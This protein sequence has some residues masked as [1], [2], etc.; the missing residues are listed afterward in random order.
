MCVC[1]CV[2]VCVRERERERLGGGGGRHEAVSQ[3][4]QAVA[5]T[6]ICVVKVVWGQVKN[7]SGSGVCRG[8]CG[9]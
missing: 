7:L 3:Y 5:G 6:L 8:G 9:G 1:V 4:S 2:C